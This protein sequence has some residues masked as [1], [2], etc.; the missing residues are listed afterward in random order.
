MSVKL[1]YVICKMNQRLPEGL[2]CFWSI[3]ASNMLESVIHSLFQMRGK[4]DISMGSE[5]ILPRLLIL[6]RGTF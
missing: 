2:I 6:G 4:T 5:T 3:F 1:F